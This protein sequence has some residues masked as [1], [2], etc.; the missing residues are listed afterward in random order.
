MGASGSAIP[1]MQVQDT[2]IRAKI[3]STVIPYINKFRVASLSWSL[4]KFNEKIALA[5]APLCYWLLTLASKNTGW[6]LPIDSSKP[7]PQNQQ[8]H[9]TRIETPWMQIAFFYLC[10]RNI[11]AL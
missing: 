8:K 11:C 1:R 10:Q 4:L 6:N 7:N 3:I 2:M 5:N 9:C